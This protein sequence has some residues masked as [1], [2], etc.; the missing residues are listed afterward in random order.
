[1]QEIQVQ[2]LGGNDTLENEIATHSSILA[3]E[4][5]WTEEPDGLQ[6]ME[7]QRVGPD[8]ACIPTT[9]GYSSFG[10]FVTIIPLVTVPFP[11]GHHSA[12]SMRTAS[13]HS[14]YWHL[15]VRECLFNNL[16]DDIQTL[17]FLFPHTQKR[18]SLYPW[19][20][21]NKKAHWP[22]QLSGLMEHQPNGQMFGE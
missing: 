20:S 21:Q 14:L 12:Q 19:A 9:I 11:I 3:W 5:P 16:G 1:M 4:I 2:S 18:Q 6:C 22:V 17:Y 13:L 10:C 15:S 7:S 8:W